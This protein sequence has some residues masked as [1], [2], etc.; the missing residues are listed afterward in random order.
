MSVESAKEFYKRIKEDEEFA[1]KISDTQDNE[2]RAK[3][4]KDEGY[5]FT[6]EELNG[7]IQKETGKKLSDE[8]LENIAGGVIGIATIISAAVG[9]G[10][11]AAGVVGANVAT[12]KADPHKG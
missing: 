11:T 6:L 7:V 3:M 2:E 4:V 12:N 9:G 5:D 8:E 10:I 1:K